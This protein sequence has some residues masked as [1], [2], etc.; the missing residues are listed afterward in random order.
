MA[1]G[2][3]N[4]RRQQPHVGTH[5]GLHEDLSAL[6]EHQA[7]DKV[8]DEAAGKLKTALDGVEQLRRHNVQH[9]RHAIAHM[10]E[11]FIHQIEGDDHFHGHIDHDLGEGHHEHDDVRRTVE[12]IGKGM[13]HLDQFLQSM[14]GPQAI[15]FEQAQ[16]L[17]YKLPGLQQYNGAIDKANAKEAA[18]NWPNV[19]LN[20][21]RG[22]ETEGAAKVMVSD[23]VRMNAQDLEALAS[24]NNPMDR[25]RALQEVLR[26]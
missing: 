21:V 16:A 11:T 14:E 13:V 7:F 25:L 5:V 2:D 10:L 3:V 1:H 18:A 20:H 6:L 23:F 15:S 22:V 19:P 24:K 26:T 12:F 17:K 4:V 8:L 9:D